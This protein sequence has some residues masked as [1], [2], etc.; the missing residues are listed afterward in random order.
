MKITVKNFGTIAEADVHI[1]GLTVI[2]GEN[3]TGK[4][5][6]GKIVFSIVKAIARYEEDLEED[7]EERVTAIVE[8]LYFTLRRKV[9]IAVQTELRELFHPRK[10]YSQLRTERIESIEERINILKRL[11]H[12]EELST[13]SFEAARS[14]LLKIKYIMDE[15]DDEISAINRAIRKA[16]FSEFRGEI[17]QKGHVLPV[18]ASLEINDGASQLIDIKWT[19][20]GIYQFKYGDD[21]GYSDA[22]YV[23]SPAIIQFHNLVRMAKTLFDNGEPGRLTVPLHLKDLAGKLSDSI[24]SYLIHVDLFSDQNDV[25]QSLD[26]SKKINSA[27][28]GEMKYDIEKLDFLL[29]RDGY[30]VS[31]SNTAS[32]I[33]SLGILDLLVKGGNAS[34]N[35]LLILDEPEVNLHP[36]WQVLYAELI[37]QLV[38]SGVDIIITTHSPYIID[39]LKF[40]SDKLTIKNHFYLATKFPGEQYSTFMDISDNISYAIDLLAAPL[41]IFSQE[42]IDDF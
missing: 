36:K 13:L 19:K 8:R 18:K 16:F 5:T 30:A 26:I 7:K 6:I 34:D 4:S 29:E 25:N 37:C 20:D 39:A 23:D 41:N 21:L 33:K 12:A 11:E 10:F 24:Y 2:T 27:F 40:Y 42:I 31:S 32:G 35:S 15:P 38:K 28:N 1:G 3:D 22:T 9:N 17:I 14:E